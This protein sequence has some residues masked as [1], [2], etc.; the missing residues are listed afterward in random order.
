MYKRV[1]KAKLGR[2]QTH[3]NSLRRNLLRSL[4]DKNSI[5]T[6]TAKAKVLKQDATSLIAEGLSK[7]EE[8]SFRRNMKNV[9]GSDE[10]LKKFKEYIVKENVGVSLVKVGF[11]SGDNAEETRVFL[12]GMEKKRK[13]IKKIEK[14]EKGEEKKVA[15]IN[16]KKTNVVGNEKR[17]DKTAVI[18]K[19]DR[20]TSRSGL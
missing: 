5:V 15:E 9:L 20:S 4:F 18:K 1:K 6:S 3:R 14:K 8:L 11:R 2:K 13:I 19:T 10:L 12:K 17:V 7:K 16:E